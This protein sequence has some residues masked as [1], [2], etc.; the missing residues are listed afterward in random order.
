VSSTPI[1]SEADLST[2][3]SVFRAMHARAKA[4]FPDA[5]SFIVSATS[6]SEGVEWSLSH[7]SYA[8]CEVTGGYR[9]PEE[10]IEAMVRQ[11][12]PPGEKARLLREEAAQLLSRAEHID[13][14]QLELGRGGAS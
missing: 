4:T 6:H 5:H 11:I 1:V 9:R 3:I 12:K 7:H 13:A 8:G 2:A 14:K 10:A